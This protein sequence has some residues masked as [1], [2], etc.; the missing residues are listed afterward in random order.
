MRVVFI[1]L[2]NTMEKLRPAFFST[3]LYS[4]TKQINRRFLDL[5]LFIVYPC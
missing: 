3:L 5:S 1:D 4:R 2:L